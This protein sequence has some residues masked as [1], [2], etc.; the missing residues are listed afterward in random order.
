MENKFK[1]IVTIIVL[2]VLA[3][4]ALKIIGFVL[5]AILP[6]A[7]LAGIGYVIFRLI[8]KNSRTRS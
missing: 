6:L 3:I 2:I 4:I 7:V 8:N 5:N 1:K